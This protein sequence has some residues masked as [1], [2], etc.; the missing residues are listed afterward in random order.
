MATERISLHGGAQFISPTRLAIVTTGSSSCPSVPDEL[1]VL[2][3]GVIRI[4]LITGSWADGKLVAHA[5]PN[6]ACTADYGTTP[7]VVAIDPKE[8]DVHHRVKVLFFYRNSK[9]PIVRV[10]APLKS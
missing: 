10:A 2:L 7:M 5:P 1:T 8:I 9:K 4:H 6:G 3:P